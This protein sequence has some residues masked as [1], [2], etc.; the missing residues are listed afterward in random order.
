[1][2]RRTKKPL[3]P[4]GRFPRV[5]LERS[6]S[7]PYDLRISQQLREIVKSG[8]AKVGQPFWSEVAFAEK[9]GVSKMTVRQAFQTLRSEGL[10][11][12]EKGK[13]PL[14]GSGH[15]V[16]N[17]NELRGFTEEMM[18][19]GLRP[20]TRLLRIVIRDRDPETASAL[21]LA[22]GQKVY[23]LRRLRSAD[24]DVVGLE[25]VRVPAGLF[26]DLEKQDLENQSLYF[27][28]ENVYSVKLVW[29]EE[30]FEA[31]P[32]QKE[33]ARL[34]Q[35]RTGFP[36]FCM[37]RTVYSTDQK[38]VEHGLS[39]FRSDRYVAVGKSRRL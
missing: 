8:P 9:L 24:E 23:E 34:L 32:A 16:K 29:S 11:L 7:V 36:L 31:I 3:T 35:V 4:G 18:R 25:T 30:K 22:E 6:S 20:S 27:T 37:H 12:I 28:L 21:R 5:V 1:M 10:L 14:V 39:V 2:N 26:P 17:F 13:R 38:P 19:R 33:D 15:T